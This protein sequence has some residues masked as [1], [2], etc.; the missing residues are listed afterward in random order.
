MSDK[1][2]L[3]DLCSLTPKNVETLRTNGRDKEC[4]TKAF[5]EKKAKIKEV[6]EK[7]PTDKYRE[8]EEY[9]RKYDSVYVHKKIKELT[10][11]KK[12]TL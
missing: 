1:L 4:N 3:F 11:T 12:H 6:K 5:T 2:N 8:I 9:D 7:A 10:K